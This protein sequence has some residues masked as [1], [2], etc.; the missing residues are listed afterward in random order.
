[1]FEKAKTVDEKV[2]RVNAEAPAGE[3]RRLL[4]VELTARGL[5]EFSRTNPSI[6]ETAQLPDYERSG[7]MAWPLPRQ[8]R[9][10]AAT[11]RNG[12]R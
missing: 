2:H 9:L 11:L 6:I 4:G 7:K 1:M 3:H 12:G 10:T 5:L 8:C